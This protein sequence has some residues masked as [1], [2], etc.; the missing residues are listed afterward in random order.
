MEA[1][2]NNKKTAEEVSEIIQSRAKLYVA[3]RK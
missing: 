1:F 3:E 2:W